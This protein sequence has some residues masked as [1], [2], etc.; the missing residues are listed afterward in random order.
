L[1]PT[2]VDSSAWLDYLRGEPQAF[3]RVDRLVAAGRAAVTGPIWAEVL[4]GARTS[5]AFGRLRSLFEGIDCVAD[6]PSLWPRV[7]EHRFALARRG[8][9]AALVDLTIAIAAFDGG[10]RL[11]TRDRNFRRIRTVIPIELELF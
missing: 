2:I 8:F 6:P 9:Q 7:A 3:R 5:G 4:S 11:L 1:T 10:F